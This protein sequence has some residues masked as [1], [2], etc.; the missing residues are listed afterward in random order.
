MN[1]LI[2]RGDAL[3][4]VINADG[5]DVRVTDLGRRV[6]WLLDESTRLVARDVERFDHDAFRAGVSAVLGTGLARKAG[7]D[8]ILSEHN[9]PAGRVR[10]RWT[11]E[12]DRLRVFAE[13]IDG[14]DAATALALPGTFRPERGTFLSAVPN[15]QGIL[16]TGKGPSFYRPLYGKGHG[17]G[18][19]MSM[20]GQIAEGACLL[21]ISEADADAALHWEKTG[22]GE[23]RLMWMQHPSMGALSYEREVVFF[24]CDAN[25]TAACKVFRRYVKEKGRFRSWEEKIAQ[26]PGLEQLFGAALVFLG[27]FE[28]KACDYESSFRRLR[29]LG[30]DR[31]IVYPLLCRCTF[32]VKAAFGND[33]ADLTRFVPVVRQ[34]GYVPGSFIYTDDGESPEGDDL[35]LD[36]RGKPMLL[37][38]IN[39][40][41]WFKLSSAKSFTWAKHFLDEKMNGL[42]F[43]HFDVIASRVS[44]EDYHPA[45]R[46]DARAERDGRQRILEYAGSKGLIISSEGF[47]DRLTPYY[48]LGN[49]KYPLALGGDEYCVVPMTMLV[50]HD[51]AYHTWWE[52]DNYNNPQAQ[53]KGDRGFQDRFA[54]GGGRSRQQACMD[55]LMGTPPDIFPFGA[56]YGYVPHNYPQSYIYRYR[57]DDA[58]VRDAIEYAKPVMALNRRVGRHEMVEHKL[59]R[60]DG[61]LQETTFADGTRVMVNFANIALEIPTGG[62]QMA[63]ESWRLIPQGGKMKPW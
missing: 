7:N 56:Q 35:A 55:A 34:L 33:M 10:L 62:G 21:T 52:V 60:P 29:E 28:D 42:G 1:Q 45:H 4:L 6:T 14:K 63:A 20:F 38:T 54:F 48:D 3:E 26:R 53:A 18:F 11:M 27:Y 49:S 51:S 43:V 50:Y 37:W 12:R 46:T 16:H 40:L 2:L 57:L 58:C 59:L 22:N 30:I 24:P 41:Q 39:D 13:A 17:D 5:T 47:Y 15:C 8:T 31:A 25:V 23:M 36:S 44:F 61:A 32:N 19:T 9:T